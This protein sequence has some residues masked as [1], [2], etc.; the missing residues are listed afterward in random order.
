M[1]TA[2]YSAIESD[3]ESYRTNKGLDV[4]IFFFIG[5]AGIL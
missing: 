4:F 5:V 2:Y 3:S 1:V